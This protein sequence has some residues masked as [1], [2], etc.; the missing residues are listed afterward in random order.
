MKR[1]K[2]DMEF[3][4]QLSVLGDAYINDA[5]GTYIGPIEHGGVASF[6]EQ[7]FAGYLMLDEIKYLGNGQYS[8]PQHP[9]AAVLGVKDFGK[10]E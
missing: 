9:F 1:E 8:K 6:F 3:A 10:I 5:F 4:K 2:N 7:I